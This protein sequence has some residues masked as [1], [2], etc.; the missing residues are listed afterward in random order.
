LVEPEPV[1]LEH[2]PPPE[3]RALWAKKTRSSRGYG[4][5]HKAVR[6]RYAELVEAGQAV[7]ARCGR[8]I[9]PGTPWDLDHGP[10]R[11]SY[12]GPSHRRCKRVAGA[13]NGA[14]V[15]NAGRR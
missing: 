14:A 4:A 8:L 10:D 12:L 6:A 5:V 15:T 2:R 13:K 1:C 11:S 3:V 9:V 7:C